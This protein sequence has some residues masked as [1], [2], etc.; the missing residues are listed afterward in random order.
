VEIKNAVIEKGAK[1]NHLS[2]LGDARWGGA[3]IGAGT[4]TAIM[5]LHKAITI[6]GWGFIART[7]RWWRV[8][9]AT[10]PS[11]RSSVITQDVAADAL[12]IARYAS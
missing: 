2:Y 7:P 3:N 1:A 8:K 11:P 6:S 12:A 9:I 4:I 10:A 5:T